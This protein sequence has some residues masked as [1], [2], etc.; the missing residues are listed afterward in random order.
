[1][2]TFTPFPRLITDRLVLRQLQMEDDEEIF[3][4]RSDETV[5]KY[6]VA[7]I[8]KSIQDARDFIGKINKAISNGESIYWAIT[9]KGDN[10]LI[11]TI[12]IW[13]IEPETKK[14]EIGYVLHPAYSGR[15]FMQ[16]AVTTVIQYGFRQMKLE[17]LDAVLHPQNKKSIIL[18]E[19]CGF[20]Y[21]EESG[22]EA[23]FRLY[24]D[25]LRGL[26]G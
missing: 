15:G 20:S 23:V 11:G 25:I 8:A 19:K 1:M 17:C 5:N 13:N 26:S 9:V 24:N 16:E 22:D 6:L 7:P 14:A 3:F 12:C 18:L 10:K 21:T 4:L 2:F